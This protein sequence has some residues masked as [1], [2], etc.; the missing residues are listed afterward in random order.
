MSFYNGILNHGDIHESGQIGPRGLPGI[1]YKLTSDGDY[2]IENKKLTNIK[3][4][5]DDKDAMTKYQ[6]ESYVGRQTQYLDGAL[7][8]QVTNNKAVIYSNTGSVHSNA[9][10]LKDRFGQEVNFHTEDQDDNQIRLYIPNLKNNDSYGGRLKSS[11]VITS[12]NQTIEGKKVFHNIEVPTPK[13]D[14]HACNKHYVDLEISKMADDSVNSKYVKKS[15]DILTGKLL[16]PNVLYPIQGDLR[17]ILSYESMREIFLSRRENR[18][19][20]TN[21]DMS[22]HTIDNVKN[23]INKDQ[24]INKGQFDNALVLE[25]DKSDLLQY[26][27]TN[28]SYP[29]AGALN[30]NGNRIYRIPDPKLADEPATLGYVSKMNHNLFNSYL[31][32]DGTR[33]MTGNLKMNS[34]HITGLTQL[35]NANDQATNKKYV[36]DTISKAIIKPSHT[37][38]NILKY[39]M[40]DIDQTSSEYG[41]ELDKIGNLDTSFHSYNKRTLYLKL[42]KDENDYEGRIGYN[43]YLLVDKTKDKYY[44]AVIEWLTADNNVWNKMEIFNNITEGS[45]ISNHTNKFEDG[46][47][48]YYTRSIIQFKVFSI[49]TAPIYLLSTIHIKNI[50]PTYP[51][52][53]SEINN[54]IYGIVGNTSEVGSYVYDA[55]EAFE[56]NKTEMK[57]LVALD[58]NNK[59]LTNI[60][61]PT[62]NF[63]CS[64][65]EYVD[66]SLK[67]LKSVT[68]IYLYGKVDDRRLF[69]VQSIALSMHHVKVAY[70]RLFVPLKYRG[71]DDTIIIDGGRHLGLNQ[72]HITYSSTK[73]YSGIQID[74]FFLNI[75]NITL[76]RA[77]KIPFLL[78]YRVYI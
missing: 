72:Y 13:I 73:N 76:L 8:A 16:V 46:E 25:A 5:D 17:Q 36:D 47:G 37:P 57:M 6:I 44:T 9:L 75:D 26:L 49:S 3:N 38:K 14:A 10:Y 22:N 61:L 66:I 42:I 62:N 15:G 56:I 59:S 43:I 32:L 7:P 70:I 21:L 58:M 39:I 33:K 28:G 67:P 35:P 40:D 74:H 2:D 54:I 60:K 64:N 51:Q 31:D 55:H 27:K 68:N 1:G 34:N 50:N 69:T 11:V 71:L 4:G 52:K 78:I 77:K 23:A 53:F 45:I 63:D 29:M 18:A 12:I 48:M 24:C 41:M 30:M 19:M 20:L 65:K